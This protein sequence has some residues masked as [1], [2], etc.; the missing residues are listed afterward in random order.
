MFAVFVSNKCSTFIVCVYTLAYTYICMDGCHLNFCRSFHCFFWKFFSAT[1]KITLY[2]C[3]RVLR[4]LWQIDYSMI[5]DRLKWRTLT[6]VWVY[7]CI[8]IQVYVHVYVY[9]CM[10]PRLWARTFSFQS[11][12]N[13]SALC[14]YVLSIHMY[15]FVVAVQAFV[16]F[17]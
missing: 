13:L 11:D 5:Y 17:V 3:V 16:V 7:S 6:Y 4:F 12:T 2:G 9:V 1:V 10:L 15:M 8:H 14:I